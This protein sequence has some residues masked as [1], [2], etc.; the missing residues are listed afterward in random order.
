M[1]QSPP[2]ARH[3]NP[4]MLRTAALLAVLITMPARAA[5]PP[6]VPLWPGVAPGEKADA[7][8]ESRDPAKPNDDTIRVTNVT[9]PTMTIFRAPADKATGAAVLVFPGGGYRIL[10]WNKEGTEVAEWLNSLGVT[11]FVVKYRVP[12]HDGRE[13]WAAPLQDAQ[14][15]MGLVRQHAAEWGIDPARV[16]VLGFS[17]GGHLAAALSTNFDKRTYDPVDAADQ[18]SCR[19]DFA[20]LIYP[21]GVVVRNESKLAPEI[22]VT[23][24]T[25]RAFIAMAEDDPVRVENA[26]SYF[27]ALKGAKVPAEMHLYPTGGHGYGLRPS[28][29]AV[30]TWPQRA[31]E[32]LKLIG[33]LERK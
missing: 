14:R 23:A 8:P 15:A 2:P 21:G 19:P 30:S 26:L 17:A 3:G 5:E 16:G 27:L 12:A 29:H 28:K 10:A 31:A 25:P 22:K 9:K 1:V 32:W 4:A 24:Q 6:V 11:A 7:A 20:V 33:A 13:K 18:L